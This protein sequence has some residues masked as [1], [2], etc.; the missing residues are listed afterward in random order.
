VT[1]TRKRNLLRAPFVLFVR[2]PI[3]LPFWLL[4]RL[5]EGAE[6]V[7]TRYLDKLPGFEVEPGR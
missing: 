5:G 6:W 7:W 1:P 2:V 4:I 3:V